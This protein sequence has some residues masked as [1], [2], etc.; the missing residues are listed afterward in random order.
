MNGP[1]IAWSSLV[2]GQNSPETAHKKVRPAWNGLRAVY[3]GPGIASTSFR[4]ARSDSGT[5]WKGVLGQP[6]ESMKKPGAPYNSPGSFQAV[7]GLFWDYK[8]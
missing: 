6:K 5:A 7:L 8:P 4:K 2:R 1:R 3:N